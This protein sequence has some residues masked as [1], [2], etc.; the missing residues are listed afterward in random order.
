MNPKKIR[1]VVDVGCKKNFEGFIDRRSEKRR[2]TY[3]RIKFISVFLGPLKKEIGLSDQEIYDL[4]DYFKIQDGRVYY[5][6]LCEVVHGEG[7]DDLSRNPP[8]TSGLEWD[9]PYH[10]NVL[11]V[12]EERRLRV[13]LTKLATT[14]SARRLLLRPYFQDY[15]LIAKNNG[16]VTLPHF[17]RIFHFL[18]IYLSDDDY[19]ILVKKFL[20]N[21][22]TVNYIAFLSALDLI[23]K[24]LIKKGN[25][26]VGGDFDKLN[27][28][29]VTES[30]FRR[31]LDAV[32]IS[33]YGPKRIYLSPVE[34]DLVVDYYRERS[35]PTRILWK[36]FVS[37]FEQETINRDLEKNP[38]AEIMYPCKELKTIPRTGNM[39]NK[40]TQDERDK[41]EDILSLIKI[42]VLARRI[43]L[44]SVFGDM[45][46]FKA[47]ARPNFVDYRQF[48]DKIEEVF[49]QK[50]LHR[51]PLIEPIQHI[52]ID[53]GENNFLNFEERQ[54]LSSAM[55]KIVKKNYPNLIDFYRCA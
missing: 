19:H 39:W 55:Q 16:A 2:G 49:T 51:T 17:Y 18:K 40:L 43:Q 38:E 3:K 54:A 8:L 31:C 42:R 33:E 1:N 52:P 53:D 45:D 29:R 41:C 7:N 21:G 23:T 24:E 5:S 30:V 32:G 12:S 36:A 50:D 35:D 48:C 4:A 14:V 26:D 28:G 15:E 34:I 47:L 13:L 10:V 20:K 44:R 9:F 11:S 37:N 27:S 6:Q 25:F 22:Y 46:H